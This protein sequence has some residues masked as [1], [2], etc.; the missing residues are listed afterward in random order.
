MPQLLIK[1]WG[2]EVDSQQASTLGVLG[3]QRSIQAGRHL[4]RYRWPSLV[5]GRFEVAVLGASVTAG[6]GVL[7]PEPRCRFNGSWG[8]ELGRW[9]QAGWSHSSSGVRQVS[10]AL[11][12]KN[13]VTAD[14]FLQCPSRFGLSADTAVV[15][16]ETE[17]AMDLYHVDARLRSNPSR[18]RKS[19]PNMDPPDQ[20]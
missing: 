2:V 5:D 8:H 1:S 18:F 12:G 19:F 13:A 16:L 14:Y 11:Y 10:I 20:P 7:S 9:L 3:S 4:R 6:C 17:P 15:L